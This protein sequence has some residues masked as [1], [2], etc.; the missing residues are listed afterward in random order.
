MKDQGEPEQLG[1]RWREIK[2]ER[3]RKEK[4]SDRMRSK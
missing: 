3:E 2:K 4:N 1:K